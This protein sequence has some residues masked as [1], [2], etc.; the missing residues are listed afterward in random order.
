MRGTR[1]LSESYSVAVVS[2]RC[3]WTPMDEFVRHA[4]PTRCVPPRF[5]LSLSPIRMRAQRA[6]LLPGAVF[7]AQAIAPS[8][9]TTPSRDRGGGGGFSHVYNEY[10]STMVTLRPACLPHAHTH[11]HLLYWCFVRSV[12]LRCFPSTLFELILSSCFKRFMLRAH[13]M[14]F[15]GPPFLLI[16]FGRRLSL[17]C[18]C[19]CSSICIE[20]LNVFVLQ[21]GL[22]RWKAGGMP[23]QEENRSVSWYKLKNGAIIACRLFT[24]LLLVYGRC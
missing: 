8:Q 9:S 17:G 13:S 10:P 19:C 11:R 20:V 15:V 23:Q 6:S 4:Q 22:F 5:L 18:C 21:A 2:W 24:L 14:S 12:S 1:G 3:V 16:S 7:H